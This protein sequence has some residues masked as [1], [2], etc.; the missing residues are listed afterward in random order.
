MIVMHLQ[1]MCQTSE[2]KEDLLKIPGG[3]GVRRT[4]ELLNHN[5]GGNGNGGGAPG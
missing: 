4:M 3:R 5:G 1:R 2:K